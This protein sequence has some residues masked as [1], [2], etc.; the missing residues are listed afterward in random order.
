MQPNTP[1]ANPS[2]MLPA[3]LL[4]QGQTS[5]G[6]VFQQN[7]LSQNVSPSAMGGDPSL[8]TPPPAGSQAVNQSVPP[9]M[10]AGQPMAGQPDNGQAPMS[11]SDMILQALMKR[12]ESGS[13]LTHKTADT[14][15]S[16]IQAQLPTPGQPG[17]PTS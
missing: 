8:Q 11:E 6:Q 3:P 16:M 15:I 13:K 14:I 10:Q 4:R 9:P 17:Q 2:Q 5:P 12:L 1:T 7:P